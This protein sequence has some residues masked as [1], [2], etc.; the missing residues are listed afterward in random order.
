MSHNLFGCIEGDMRRLCFSMAVFALCLSLEA[1]Y[2]SGWAPVDAA[3][4]HRHASLGLFLIGNATVQ[5]VQATVRKDH[6]NPLFNQDRPWETRIDN[7]YPNVVFDPSHVDGAWRLWCSTHT[8][9][10]P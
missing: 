4:V 8:G 10:R 5:T 3:G 9:A 6:R 1:H 7:G 2:F